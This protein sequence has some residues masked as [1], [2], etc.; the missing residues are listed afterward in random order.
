MP[1]S[2]EDKIKEQAQQY[3]D[4][5]EHVLAAFVAQP[6]GATTA[7]MAGLGPSSIGGIKTSKQKRAAE[8]AGLELANPMALALTESRLLVLGISQPI[9]LGKGGDVKEL[10]SAA[11][12]T[13]V[14]SIEVKRLLVG[15]TVTVTVRGVPIKLEAGGGANAKGLAE[16]FARMKAI[17]SGR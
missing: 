11:L 14:D 4:A 8:E 3:L 15:K 9:A 17:R 1:T 5:G 10:V 12:L 7:K 6:R 16:E 13:E 2:Y